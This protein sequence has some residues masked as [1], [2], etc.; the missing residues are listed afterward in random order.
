VIFV[1]FLYMHSP[2]EPKFLEPTPSET[3]PK[4]SELKPALEEQGLG[5]SSLNQAWRVTRKT[6][7]FDP[8]GARIFYSFPS[9]SL[10]GRHFAGKS[11]KGYWLLNIIGRPR[12]DGETEE[13]FLEQHRDG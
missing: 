7:D 12:S 4:L 2:P 8:A 5:C 13:T 3:V 11:P 6:G 10:M 1:Q 9:F